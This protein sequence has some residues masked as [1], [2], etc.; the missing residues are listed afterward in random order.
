M[1]I[2]D[3]FIL[4]SYI[5]ADRPNNLEEMKQTFSTGSDGAVRKVLQWPIPDH[6]HHNL[7]LKEA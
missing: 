7:F 2:D 6:H 4:K 3:V 1:A 5:L